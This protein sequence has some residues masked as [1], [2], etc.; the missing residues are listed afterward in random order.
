[1]MLDSVPN[2]SSAWSGTGTVVV[3]L[4]E[5]PHDAVWYYRQVA[6]RRSTCD[7]RRRG[8]SSTRAGPPANRRRSRPTRPGETHCF[9][10]G[11][12]KDTTKRISLNA[13]R[14]GVTPP[15]EGWYD[16]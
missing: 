11:V 12:C 10:G 3:A 2:V 16:R 5:C 15:R 8:I 13:G 6:P 1:M 14:F 9:A 7:R 4:P